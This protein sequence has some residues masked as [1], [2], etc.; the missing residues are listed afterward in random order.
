[1]K[2]WTYLAFAA[3]SATVPAAQHQSYG[4]KRRIGVT[5]VQINVSLPGAPAPVWDEEINVG[6]GYPPVPTDLG[7]GV[8][9]ML[10]SSL[11][12]THKFLVIDQ[13]AAAQADMAKETQITGKASAPMQAQYKVEGAITDFRWSND[14]FGM[15]VMDDFQRHEQGLTAI[16]GIDLRIIDVATGE[17]WR[18]THSTGR[19]RGRF[20]VTSFKDKF[21]SS[22]FKQTP[23][24]RA[25]R[26]AVEKAVASVDDAGS[27]MSW[28]SKIAQIESGEGKGQEIY[29]AGGEE[30]GIL[31]G[32]VFTVTRDGKSIGKVKVSSVKGPLAIAAPVEGTDFMVGDSVAYAK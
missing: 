10:I 5:N 9:E 19:V 29:I 12:N 24:G 32:D 3:L 28:A 15:S 21:Q 13:T 25:V 22:E 27:E 6:I 26:Q 23:L 11:E 16:V 14:A 20:V 31:V 1:V 8:T 2:I 30:A 4:P 17:V 7:T 18:S